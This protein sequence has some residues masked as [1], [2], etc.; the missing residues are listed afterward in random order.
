MVFVYDR[1]QVLDTLCRL[2]WKR[3]LEIDVLAADM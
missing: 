2:F 1:I 3:M